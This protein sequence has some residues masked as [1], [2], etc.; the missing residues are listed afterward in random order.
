M[1]S[2]ELIRTLAVPGFLFDFD[3]PL[4]NVFAGLPAPQVAQDLGR[5]VLSREPSLRSRVQATNDPLV[6]MSLAYEADGQLGEDA[7]RALTAAEVAAVAVAGDPTRGAVEALHEA[8]AAGRRI[9]VVS[10]NSA[11]CVCAFLERHALA[12]YVEDIVG[13]PT[14]R[15]D[16][17]KPSP[18]SL[19]RAAENLGVEIAKCTLIGD[20]L[21]DIEA[22]HVAGA[23]AVG[24]ANKP[25]KRLAFDRAGAD[26]I[27]D[28]MGEIAGALRL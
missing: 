3:G 14:G 2:D 26:S 12:Q 19:L 22:A 9:A 20:S 7:E 13:R 17:M 18:H 16:L 4:C 21:T 24:Y 8:R 28:G 11:D 1:P 25:H 27:I 15:P 23:T 5:L 6:V 10:N